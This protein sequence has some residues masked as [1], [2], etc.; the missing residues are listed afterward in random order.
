MKA[1]RFYGRKDIRVEEI[2]E[3]A[4]AAIDDVCI[5]V[6]FCGICGTD[7]HEYLDG[8]IVTCSTPHVLTGATLPQTLGHE[9]SGKVVDKGQEVSGLEIGDRVAIMPAIV[10]GQCYFCKRGWGHL[11]MKFAATG[12]SAAT[13]GMARFAVV[14]DYQAIRLPDQV[15][16]LEG[17]LIEPAAVAAYGVDRAGVRGGDVVLVAGAGP[18]GILTAMYVRAVGASTVIISEPNARRAKLAEEMDLGPVVNPKSDELSSLVEDLTEGLGVDLSVECSGS[19]SGLNSCLRLTRA[20]GSVVQ[21]GLH[22][23]PVTIDA[24]ALANKDLTLYG[25]WCWYL[26]DWSRIANMVANGQ[27]PVERLVT[28]QIQLSEVVTRGFDALV[29]SASDQLKI[30]VS[31]S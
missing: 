22:S 6:F 24:M 26:T 19:E 20:R 27:L 3:P 4:I 10:C 13:G 28:S 29:D 16:N 9:F 23:K 18:I 2:A 8:P 15:T 17:A 21:T 31:P 11:C 12:L 5:E 25:S 1:A 14:K 7:L 30:L